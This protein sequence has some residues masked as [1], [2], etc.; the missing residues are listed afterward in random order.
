MEL[1]LLIFA[2][3]AVTFAARY[4]MIALLGRWQVPRLVTRALYYVPIA[5][6]SALILP[7]LVTRAGQLTLAPDNPRLI[8]GVAA[9]VVAAVTRRMLLTIAVGMGVMWLAQ[10]VLA[11]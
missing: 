1:A 4:V 8:G 3:A 5:A 7:E 11:R 9:I 6:F 10:A 2:M